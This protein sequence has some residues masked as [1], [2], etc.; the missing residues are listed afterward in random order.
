MGLGT[1][2]WK[3]NDRLGQWNV[4]QKTKEFP[5]L[6]KLEKITKQYDKS[7]ITINKHTF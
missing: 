6:V 7:S 4:F 5:L 3:G 1:R 2:K